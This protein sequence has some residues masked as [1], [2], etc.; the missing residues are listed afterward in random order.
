ML[1][2]P[3]HCDA[4]GGIGPRSLNVSEREWEDLVAAMTARTGKG[5]QRRRMYEKDQTSGAAAAAPGDRDAAMWEATRRMMDI[6]RNADTA[7]ALGPQ[8][9]GWTSETGRH[10]QQHGGGHGLPHRKPQQRR[11][12]HKPWDQHRRHASLHPKKHTHEG[13]TKR[14]H[15]HNRRRGVQDNSRR[16]HRGQNR[17]VQKLARE[18]SSGLEQVANTLTMENGA[19]RFRSVAAENMYRPAT[20][21]PLRTSEGSECDNAGAVSDALPRSSGVADSEADD[22]PVAA[23]IVDQPQVVVQ[24]QPSPLPSPQ[25]T[26]TTFVNQQGEGSRTSASE[27]GES[28]YEVQ[29][30]IVG[31]GVPPIDSEHTDLGG[32]P[33]GSLASRDSLRQHVSVGSSVVGEL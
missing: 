11:N 23:R 26:T 32:A 33:R 25:E 6:V 14:W 5:M 27:S 29:R 17:R 3:Y 20:P 10:H 28:Q 30:E 4:A 31:E 2:R 13:H 21:S 1:R 18:P 19:K 15:T 9:G 22:L 24:I 7:H 12:H 16:H 8:S